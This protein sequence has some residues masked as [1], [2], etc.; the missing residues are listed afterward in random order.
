MLKFEETLEDDENLP[1]ASDMIQLTSLAKSQGKEPAHVYQLVEDPISELSLQ[2][3]CFFEDLHILQAEIQNAWV[4]F[5][6]GTMTL[7][8]AT[9][10][11]TAAIELAAR[12]EKELLSANPGVINS[13][14]SYQDLALTIFNSELLR[15][16]V[17]A[18]QHMKSSDDLVVTPFKE[19][20][21]LP[22]GRTLMRISQCHVAFEEG[23]WPIPLMPMRLHYIAMPELLDAPKMKKI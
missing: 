2:V 23:G 8:A 6:S 18:D 14:R 19:F 3:F 17:D 21:Y 22:V 7:I 1:M 13:S 12:A 20:M 10:V 16:G 9:T 15:Q 4:S 11:T 5:T